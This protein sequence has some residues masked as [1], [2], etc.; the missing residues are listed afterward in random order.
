M[1]TKML[2]KD[3]EVKWTEE[4]KES[5]KRVNKSIGEALVLESLDYTNEFLIFLFSPS[6]E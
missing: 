2:K 5:F 4:A 1:I 6:K 3:N